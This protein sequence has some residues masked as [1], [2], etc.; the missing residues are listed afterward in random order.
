[1]SEMYLKLDSNDL[2]RVFQPNQPL[3]IIINKASENGRFEEISG[4][5]TILIIDSR[6]IT[7]SLSPALLDW[8]D[9][10]LPQK[11]IALQSSNSN[12]LIFFRSKILRR[13]IQDSFQIVIESPRVIIKRE[14]R[15]SKRKP[16]F[17]QINYRMLRLGN[18]D[19]KHLASKIGTGESKDVSKGGITILTNLQLPVGITLLIE[20]PLA[21]KSISMIGQVRHVR[22]LQNSDYSYVV[23]VQFIQTGPEEQDLINKTISNADGI[24]KAGLSL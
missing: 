9:L 16:L 12:E 21:G 8:F 5:A 2:C 14:R 20:F 18:Q 1:M 22:P 4:K 17:T 6:T 11:M 7:L 3:E 23:G 24:Q 19:L 13:S 15:V 10:F